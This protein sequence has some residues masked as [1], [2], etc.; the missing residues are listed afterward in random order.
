M[1]SMSHDPAAAVI[2]AQTIEIGAAASPSTTLPAVANAAS[3]ALGVGTAPLGAISSLGQG[4]ASAGAAAGP[5]AASTLAGD[6]QSTGDES[7]DPEAHDQQPGEQL[8]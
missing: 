8:L 2:G 7:G 3:T 1:T 4:G 5:A 6:D